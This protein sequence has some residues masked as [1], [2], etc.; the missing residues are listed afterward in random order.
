[1]SRFHRV[2]MNKTFRGMVS[3]L[4]VLMLSACG[5]GGGGSGGEAKVLPS[6]SGESRPAAASFQTSSLN[7]SSVEGSPVSDTVTV[8]MQWPS[9]EDVWIYAE[10][11]HDLVISGDADIQA[12]N[13]VANL[14]F[15]GDLPVGM[16]DSELILHLCKDEDCTREFPD[17]PKRLPIHYQVKPNI[18]VQASAVLERTGRDAAPSQ[19]LVA[20]IPAEAGQVM[21]TLNTVTPQAMSATLSGKQLTIQTTQ[22]K[23]G[24]YTGTVV[25]AS[26]SDSRYRRSVDVRYTVKPPPGGEV[27]LAVDP[28]DV[29]TSVRQGQ[30]ANV[31]FKV[32]RPSWT[33]QWFA[34]VVAN[35]DAIYSVRDLGNDE[36]ELQ[37]NGVNAPSNVNHWTTLKFS[38]GA[39]ATDV[40]VPLHVSIA[41]V[42]QVGEW[43]PGLGR[44]L[45]EQSTQADLA[46]SA[47]VKAFDGA[48]TWTAVAKVPW[49]TL[50]KSSG[51]TDVDDL[52]FKVDQAYYL[53]QH[54]LTR[55]DVIDV[56]INRAGVPPVTVNLGLLNQISHLDR[57]A[58]GPLQGAAGRVYIA[59]QFNPMYAPSGLLA[60]GYLHV[61]GATLVNAAIVPGGQ[62]LMLDLSGAQPG[63]PVQVSW[64]TNLQTSRLAVDVLPSTAIPV[65]YQALPYGAYRPA[66]YA[67]GLR[68]LYWSGNG[69][70]FRWAQDGLAWSFAQAAVGDVADMAVSP[71]G[72]RLYTASGRT[73]SGYDPVSLTYLNQGSYTHFYGASTGFAFEAETPASLHGLGIMADGRSF[74][75]VRGAVTSSSATMDVVFFKGGDPNGAGLAAWD[76]AT[77]PHTPEDRTGSGFALPSVGAGLIMSPG[78][79]A[80]V[81]VTPD[82]WMRSIDIATGVNWRDRGVLAPGQQLVS[83]S[84][85]GMVFLH[86]DGVM[87]IGGFHS[88]NLS[89]VLPPT[90]QAG[91]YALT[92]D[93]RYALVY[94]YRLTG[95][96]GGERAQDATLWILDLQGVSMS[97]P[98]G[99]VIVGSIALPNAVGC[100][101]PLVAG[102]TCKHS[103]QLTVD[104]RGDAVFVLGPR[105]VAAVPLSS[106]MGRATAQPAS[107]GSQRLQSQSLSAKKPLRRMPAGVTFKGQ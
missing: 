57:V 80:L 99:A 26:Q 66:Q 28:P 30:S 79:S 76:L 89:T 32:T 56:S 91:G 33:S 74:A 85:D 50:T 70:I 46:F 77:A 40:D 7:V 67:P 92:P 48:A 59:G 69:K 14:T 65:G 84:D 102:E 61:D 29:F 96:A 25:L 93:G 22:V 15:S 17:S 75:S 16:H 10:E 101:G 35:A 20:D 72:A 12:D 88:G 54:E 81:A 86:S 38:A 60:G 78:S 44:A 107:V 18:H 71:D 37:I 97:N 73:I 64:A 105:G 47:P 31:R 49:I 106:A 45:G 51:T 8:E 11:P 34:P 90:Q 3:C 43:G 13:Y 1:M 63:R 4:I 53:K 9:D 83:V 103:A 24:V 2:D 58:N 104:P 94:G 19:T 52:S 27:P 55:T 23:S 68:A 21:A 36:Y 95:G 5:G 6:G 41:G 87:Q 100:T 82:G 39:T 98:T 62:A 42:F